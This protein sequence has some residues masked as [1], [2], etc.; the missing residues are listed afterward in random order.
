M[1]NGKVRVIAYSLSNVAIAGNAGEL[2][3]MNLQAEKAVTGV[4]S[5]DNV[6]VVTADGIETAIGCCGS[7]VD[8]NGTTSINSLDAA[9]VKIYTAGE[10]LVIESSNAF[11]ASVYSLNGKLVEVLNV[12]AG[13]NIYTLPAGTYV[14]GGVKVIIK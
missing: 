3:T 2:V 5:V 10:A 6:R 13:K 7:I 11:K 12:A 14:V 8:I 1:N 4:I 9:D